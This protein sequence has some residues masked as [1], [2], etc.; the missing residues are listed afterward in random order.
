MCV[1]EVSFCHL[2]FIHVMFPLLGMVWRI[3][4]ATICVHR[5]GVTDMHCY[6]LCSQGWCDGYALLQFVFT[7]MVWRLCIATICVHRDGVTDMHCYNLCSQGDYWCCN[8]LH[9]TEFLTIDGR[10]EVEF[11]GYYSKAVFSH[12]ISITR[13]D[14]VKTKYD[15]SKQARDKILTLI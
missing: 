10:K 9:I 13:T 4:I 8:S 15:T 6:N 5:D 11:M 7:G 3:C 2:S 14:C 12:C 1:D